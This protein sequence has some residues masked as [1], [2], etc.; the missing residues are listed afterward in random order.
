MWYQGVVSPVRIGQQNLTRRGA[1]RPDRA[2]SGSARPHAGLRG[3][4]TQKPLGASEVREAP[5]I[6]PR[7]LV[8]LDRLIR[9]EPLVASE[10]AVAV[11]PRSEAAMGADQ[12][13]L[14]DATPSC[15][16][17]LA[18]TLAVGQATLATQKPSRCRTAV[19]RWDR[20]PCFGL[21]RRSPAAQ[22]ARPSG[23]G[24]TLC[25]GRCRYQRCE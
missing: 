4:L 23:S 16:F 10:T 20:Y 7:P 18:W 3:H 17:A 1:Q 5:G 24:A 6:A 2:R 15:A 11:D 13:F 19:G 8:W 21:I 9:D 12:F 25:Q 14:Y 22:C